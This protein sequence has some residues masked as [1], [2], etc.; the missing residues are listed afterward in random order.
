MLISMGLAKP[1]SAWHYAF[2][3]TLFSVIGGC[4]G[5]V[6]GFFG[7]SI[8]EPYMLTSSYAVSYE[9]I[10]GWFDNWGIWII[11]L[12]GF[13]PIPYKLFT[14]TAGMMHM[15]FLPFVLASFVGRGAR[16]FLVS[17]LL[18][19]FGERLEQQF[20]RWIDW[21]GWGIVVLAIIGYGIIQL[22]GH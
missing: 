11:L 4:F 6:L 17:S 22:K 12:A 19:L 5:Y 13:S 1:K 16:F 2:I 8:I 21:V 15:F 3:A 18:V 10:R 9:H 7:M 20:R 14:V